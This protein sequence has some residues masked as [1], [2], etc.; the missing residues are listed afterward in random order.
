MP[1]ALKIQ[2]GLARWLIKTQIRPPL[3]LCLLFSWFLRK[4]S[5]S[6]RWKGRR[7]SRSSRRGLASWWRWHRQCRIGLAFQSPRWWFQC[8]W[9]GWILGPIR[10]MGTWWLGQGACAARIPC[11]LEHPG[12]TTSKSLGTARGR[13]RGGGAGGGRRRDI[14][15]DSISVIDCILCSYVRRLNFHNHCTAHGVAMPVAK[16][17]SVEVDIF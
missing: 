9:L 17:T 16:Y 8:R 11:P 12:W 1:A 10:S 4:S 5:G 15:S 6:F 7:R 2:Y 3:F 14:K 13:W